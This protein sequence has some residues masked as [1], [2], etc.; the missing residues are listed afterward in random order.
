MQR[1]LAEKNSL[2]LGA[3][4]YRK[5]KKRRMKMKIN[6]RKLLLNAT[7]EIKEIDQNE[8][9]YSSSAT[10]SHDDDRVF[11]HI[12]EVLK[13]NLE[14]DHKMVCI[15]KLMCK[16]PSPLPVVS[17]LESFVKSY[18]LRVVTS[19][20]P[21]QE[22]PKRRSSIIFGRNREIPKTPQIDFD[23]I[24]NEINLCKETADGLRV[25]FNFILKDFLLYPEEREYF[26]EIMNDGKFK[27]DFHELKK[28]FCFEDFVNKQEKIQV[29]PEEQ[30]SEIPEQAEKRSSRLRSHSSKVEEDE[31]LENI[32]S[33]ASTSSSCDSIAPSETFVKKG[34]FSGSWFPIKSS[35][36]TK[37]RKILKDIFEWEMILPKSTDDEAE[38]SM[39]FG[40]YH[41]LRLIVKLP[42][43]LTS[44]LMNEQKMKFLLK[45][46]DE[47]VEFLE[48]NTEL[49]GLQNFVTS[50]DVKIESL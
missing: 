40:I 48:E 47:F 27:I 33:M 15:D 1:E 38:A 44:T 41:M 20:I 8:L 2:Q 18:A 21:K 10:E 43:F 26:E 46:L 31:R 7:D 50:A 42:E 37:G 34:I 11:L 16:I 22:K 5:E 9:E 39:V 49:Y 30:N 23:E 29:K 12:G 45:F 6:E 3:Y 36:S 17:I 32:S 25:Y 24:E 28:P 4:L 35:L 14:Y 13:L 19:V